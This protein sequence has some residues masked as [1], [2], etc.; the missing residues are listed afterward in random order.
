MCDPIPCW[1]R[2]KDRIEVKT[3]GNRILLILAL[4]TVAVGA[5]AVTFMSLSNPVFDESIE[6]V[7][8]IITGYENPEEAS[9]PLA[10]MLDGYRPEDEFFTTPEI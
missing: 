8:M 1:H 6:F 2:L 3:M 10:F 7:P 4:T 5:K 9:V